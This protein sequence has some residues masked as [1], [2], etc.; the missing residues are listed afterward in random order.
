MNAFQRLYGSLSAA[1]ALA[2]CGDGPPLNRRGER[3]LRY[4]RR[5]LRRPAEKELR[6]AAN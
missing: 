6:N 3:T 5:R 2:V 4:L 1:E